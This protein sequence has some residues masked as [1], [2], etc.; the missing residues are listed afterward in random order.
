MSDGDRYMD[1]IEIRNSICKSHLFKGKHLREMVRS[2]TFPACS[3]QSDDRFIIEYGVIQSLHISSVNP[4]YPIQFFPQF[5]MDWSVFP[6]YCLFRWPSGLFSTLDFIIE[7]K[8][9][10]IGFATFGMNRPSMSRVGDINFL[11]RI[12]NGKV[13]DPIFRDT[14]GSINEFI[15]FWL[16]EIPC[17]SWYE[18]IQF[19]PY[20]R[21]PRILIDFQRFFA[22]VEF[23]GDSIALFNKGELFTFDRIKSRLKSF[24]IDEYVEESYSCC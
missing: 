6:I 19:A 17:F 2:N 7:L 16:G 14:I 24:T 9:K 23:D 13:L 3:M 1:S 4:S 5:L 12:E 11:L 21:D 18:G 20:N 10:G 22:T 8:E 15:G